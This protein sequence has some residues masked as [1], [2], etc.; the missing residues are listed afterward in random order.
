MNVKRI[1]NSTRYHTNSSGKNYE[2]I[3]ICFKNTL[4]NSQSSIL[5][6]SLHFVLTQK[7]LGNLL[8]PK[9]V[10]IRLVLVVTVPFTS[11]FLVTVKSWE[12][13]DQCK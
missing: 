2:T 6:S 3:H 13:T 1:Q 10:G 4:Q 8:I 9:I 7:K 11:L 12:T 5:S